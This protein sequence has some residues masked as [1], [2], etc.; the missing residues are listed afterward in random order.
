VAIVFKAVPLR[1]A[2]RQRQHRVLAVE[3]APST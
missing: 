3:R 1:S 2:G